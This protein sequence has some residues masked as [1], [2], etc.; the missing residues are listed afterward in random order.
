MMDKLVT[1]NQLRHAFLHRKIT[2]DTNTNNKGS[3]SLGQVVPLYELDSALVLSKPG[4]QQCNLR[5]KPFTS[6]HTRPSVR[7]EELQPTISGP[8]GT[9]HGG[10]RGVNLE[11]KFPESKV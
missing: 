1:H 4:V 8:V 7:C 9:E 3:S 6:L 2:A 5:R 11:K 10:Y